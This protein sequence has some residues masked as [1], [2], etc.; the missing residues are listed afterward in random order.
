MGQTAVAEITINLNGSFRSM[1]T[2]APGPF[3]PLNLEE[4]FR[5]NFEFS[6]RQKAQ[7]FGARWNDELDIVVQA[8]C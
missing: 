4:C 3:L 6:G 7:L 5:L 2:A 1:R 8:E